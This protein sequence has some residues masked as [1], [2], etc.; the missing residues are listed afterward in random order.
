[1]RVVSGG[2]C[3][4][5]GRG[6]GRTSVFV[7]IWLLVVVVVVRSFVRSFVQTRG[8]EGVWGGELRSWVGRWGR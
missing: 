3:A 4:V 1:M 5:D 6:H 7:W 8:F 2:V